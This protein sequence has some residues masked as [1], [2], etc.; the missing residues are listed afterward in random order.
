VQ[1]ASIRDV[2]AA[3]G[4]SI[5]TVSRVVNGVTTVDPAMRIRVEA[6]ISDLHYVPNSMARS[7]KTGSGTTIGVL[8]DSLDDAF[9]ASVVSAVE[10]G[11]LDRGLGVVVGSSGHD[12]DREREQ[13]SRLTGHGV[14]GIVLA[15]V[16]APL[17][18][19]AAHRATRPVVTI[20]RSLPGYDSVTVD[21]RA[22]ARTAVDALLDAGHR[23]IAL[24]GWDPS[25]ETAERR[26]LGYAEA[27][28]DRSLPY[29]DALV[30]RVSFDVGAA[31][32]GLREVLALREPPTALFLSNARHAASTVAALHSTARRDLALVSFGDFLLADSVQPSVSC[33][34]QDPYEI[35]GRAI[36][37]LLELLEHPRA[38]PVQDVLPTTFVERLSHTIAPR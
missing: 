37:R 8:V 14:R 36:S 2:A 32:T 26:R 29:D 22:G 35:G 9:F 6:A 16:A 5:K 11:A 15:P 28:A 3:A 4:V 23:R 1:R 21:D 25:F 31:V 7:L 18:I 19:L 38:A 34:D 27:L 13:L 10:V 30:P 24:I 20:D 33:I 17:D 12:P